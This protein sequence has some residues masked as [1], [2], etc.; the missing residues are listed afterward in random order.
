[1]YL[2]SQKNRLTIWSI[3]GMVSGLHVESMLG[4]S[5]YLMFLDALWGM[6]FN[7]RSCPIGELFFAIIISPR[8]DTNG[9]INKK[10]CST[11]TQNIYIKNPSRTKED[12]PCDCDG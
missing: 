9:L 1:M 10:Y 2:E 8:K 11:E 7:W 3:R 5:H 6:S 12:C 4:G